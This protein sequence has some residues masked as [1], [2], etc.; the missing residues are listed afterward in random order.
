MRTLAAY[1]ALWQEC[2]F[3]DVQME[4]ITQPSLHAFVA[5]FKSEALGELLGKKIDAAAVQSPPGLRERY[6][7]PAVLAYVIVS[8]RKPNDARRAADA[9][10][11]NRQC[12]RRSTIRGW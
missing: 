12:V 8:A 10:A 1:G 3:P 7:D 6:R 4:D 9:D 2:G 11:Q 5:H